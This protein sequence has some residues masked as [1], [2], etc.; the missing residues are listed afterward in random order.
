[1]CDLHTRCTP[2]SML[3]TD[4]NTRR[5]SH[6]PPGCRRRSAEPPRGRSG[7]LGR[8][9]R[10]SPA[11]GSRCLS[12]PGAASEARP[13]GPQ[14]GSSAARSS[15]SLQPADTSRQAQSRAERTRRRSSQLA[16]A[17]TLR[18]GRDSPPEPRCGHCR[19]AGRIPLSAQ[20]ASLEGRLMAGRGRP[21]QRPHT[22]PHGWA[23]GGRARKRSLSVIYKR[24]M[25]VTPSHVTGLLLGLNVPGHSG[26][27]S[28][29]G[30]VS[31]P[32]SPVN[33][34]R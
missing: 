9:L 16:R 15:F 18:A 21:R 25:N 13:P 32:Q 27:R 11:H 31:Q 6:A 12:P 30:P 10:G 24:G 29:G 22:A 5:A 28:L 19:G 17:R 4:T 33:T 23:G 26:A 34:S 3:H 1:M 20:P 7:S 8:G 2:V 14:P